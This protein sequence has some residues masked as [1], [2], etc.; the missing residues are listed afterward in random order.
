M[1]SKAAS[2]NNVLGRRESK[3]IET[4]GSDVF[5]NRLSIFDKGK[6]NTDVKK[7]ANAPKKLDMS[8]LGSFSSQ[9]NSSSSSKPENTGGVSLGI[10]QRLNMY[11]ENARNRCKTT[12]HLDP[13][14][15]ILKDVKKQGNAENI[16]EETEE[17]NNNISGDELSIS[18]GDDE[19][20]EE[21]NKDKDEEKKDKDEEKKDKDEE[22]KVKE[23][24]EDDLLDDDDL[25]D[26]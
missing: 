9:P 26:L 19:K 8:K 14:F 24:N 18:S 12:V 21:S 11:L 17:I 16:K 15:N 7:E 25:G 6:D 22:K 23:K 4:F 3:P 1:F 20:K 10:Q 13:V 5:K 2:S